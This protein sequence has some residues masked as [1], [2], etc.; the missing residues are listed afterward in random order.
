[1]SIPMAAWEPLYKRGIAI[2]QADIH[3]DMMHFRF[4]KQ[5]FS[6]PTVDVCHIATYNGY[7]YEARVSALRKLAKE[8]H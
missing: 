8:K 7:W 5:L 6:F 4:R 1:M 3:N 2:G